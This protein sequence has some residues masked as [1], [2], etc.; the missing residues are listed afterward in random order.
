MKKNYHVLFYVLF[1]VMGVAHLYLFVS[2]ITLGDR[3]SKYENLTKVLR[4]DNIDLEKKLYNV[5]SLTY[6][7]SQAAKLKFTQ[8]TTPLYLESQGI[9]LQR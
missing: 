9:A 8:K 2:G 5:E 1:L 4:Q 3:I 6:A 7:A